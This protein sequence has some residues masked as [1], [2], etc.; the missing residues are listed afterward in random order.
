METQCKSCGLESPEEWG[1][2]PDGWMQD[3]MGNWYCKDCVEWEADDID[4]DD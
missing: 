1:I 4:F 2:T 3:L